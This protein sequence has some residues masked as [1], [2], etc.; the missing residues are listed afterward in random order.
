MHGLMQQLMF[1][2]RTVHTSQESALQIDPSTTLV[3]LT[4]TLSPRPA[5]R[6]SHDQGSLAPIDG[7]ADAGNY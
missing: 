1:F 6:T 7:G 5:G 2:R 4:S 3:A